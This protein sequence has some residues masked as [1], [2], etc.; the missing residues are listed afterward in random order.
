MLY[1]QQ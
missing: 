1:S